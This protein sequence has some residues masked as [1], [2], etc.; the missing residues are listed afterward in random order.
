MHG[1]IRLHDGTEFHVKR[2][3]IKMISV[4]NIVWGLSHIN[5]FAGHTDSPIS[6][7]QHSCNVHD[8]CPPDCR[9]EGLFHDGAE[10]TGLVDIPTP[11]KDLLPGY[12]DLE[13]KTEKVIAR[14]LGLRHPWPADVKRADLI[15]LAD[16]M[17]CLTNRTDWRK[18]PFP[19]SGKII[20]PWSPARARNEFMKRY[21]LYEW[22]ND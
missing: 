15:A 2:P 21:A 22:P 10:G 7:C 13:M 18:L 16:E 3:T 6:V 5:R 8:L 14:F 17:K 12:R 11:L 1:Y 4:E 19:P 9:K 20:R